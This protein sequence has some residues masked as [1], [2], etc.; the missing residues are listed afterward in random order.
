MSTRPS[1]LPRWLEIG[2]LPVINVLMALVVAGLILWTIGANPFDAIAILI[3]GAFGSGYG[4]GYTLYYATSFIF[5]GLAV[6]VAFHAGLFNIGGEGQAYIG[7]L[8][9]GVVALACDGFLPAPL[10]VPLAILAAAGFGAAWAIVPAYLQAHRGNHIVITTIMFNFLAASLMVYLLVD[11][12]RDPGQMSTQ[13][14]TF[15]ENAT[16]PEMATV[17]A[18]FGI[19]MSSTPLNLSLIW[20]LICC[21]LVEI[22]I[23]RSRLGYEIRATGLAPRAAIYA[24]IKPGRIVMIAMAISGALAGS[25]GVNEILG[26]QHRLLLDFVAGAG[27]TGIAV[28]LMGRN[29]PFGIVLA[30]LL[31]GALY[32]G[33]AELAFEIPT[34]TREMIITIQGLIILFSGALAYMNRPWVERLYLRL[35]AAK[36]REASSHG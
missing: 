34:I 11:V 12:F 13:S 9:A 18:W 3:E 15:T 5:T 29:H 16:L 8:G 26:V 36:V 31:F 1:Q 6:A 22:F 32:Q 23:W 27:F 24:G 28:A 30:S 33:G 10:L 17:F 35:M 4:W 25:V 21:V 2:V 14:R 19:K 7:G 20:A